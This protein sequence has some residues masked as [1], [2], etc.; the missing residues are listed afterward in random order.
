MLKVKGQSESFRNGRQG[1]QLAFCHQANSLSSVSP[2]KRR[3]PSVNK[4]I[5]MFVFGRCN[6]L[7]LKINAVIVKM[8]LLQKGRK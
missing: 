7:R 5:A 4:H 8:Y 1:F 2:G 3:K 6:E